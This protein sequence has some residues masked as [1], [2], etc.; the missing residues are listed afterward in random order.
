MIRA[1]II[2]LVAALQLNYAFGDPTGRPTE[3]ETGKPTATPEVTFPRTTDEEEP[4]T[5]RPTFRPTRPPFTFMTT[6]GPNG[7]PQPPMLQEPTC[8]ID[9]NMDYFGCDIGASI[10]P[11]WQECAEACRRHKGCLFWVYAPS[12]K[13]CHY[14]NR[15]C[16][17]RAKAKLVSGNRA[18]GERC[19]VINIS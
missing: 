3:D 15:K 16:N 4:R 12:I 5:E 13:K 11:S 14:K 18:C 8:K 19:T 1:T 17:V 6:R 9:Y 2:L 10:R 7:T